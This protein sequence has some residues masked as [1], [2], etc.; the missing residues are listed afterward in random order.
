MLSKARYPQLN[1]QQRRH[2][3]RFLRTLQIDK[4]WAAGG[5][6]LLAGL[7]IRAGITP[8]VTADGAQV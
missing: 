6:W 7:M 5:G 3:K 2:P 1:R 8:R 4:G